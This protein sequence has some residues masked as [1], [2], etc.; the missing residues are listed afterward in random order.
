MNKRSLIAAAMAL[1]FG[2]VQA[3]DMLSATLTD[4][5]S[6]GGL[7]GIDSSVTGSIG[8]GTFS[9]ASTV[10][11]FGLLWTAHDGVTFGPGTYTFDTAVNNS[12][13]V[14]DTYTGLVVEAG[15][16]GGH[17]LWD[18]STGVNI[19]LVMVWDVIDNGDGTTSYYTIDNAGFVRG[20]Q[21]LPDGYNLLDGVR[22]NS[23]ADGPFPGANIFFD[24]SVA[25]VPIPAAVWLFGSGLLGLVGIA[26][27][28][29]VIL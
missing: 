26:R 10:P 14:G 13:T 4:L 3:A 25:T 12:G 22:G 28:K 27:R 5:S 1:T 18:Y 2:S 17:I 7:T 24:F 6:T 29:K 8:G 21:V 20:G 11:F 19:D 23:M 16:V 9:V 15:Q